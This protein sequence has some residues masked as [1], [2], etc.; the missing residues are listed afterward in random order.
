M[1]SRPWGDF[2][3]NGMLKFLSVA[4]PGYTGPSSRTVQRRLTKLYRK[5]KE[6]F[7]T[8]LAQ[9][10]QLS[11][12]A[13]LWKSKRNRHFL[14]ITVHYTSDDFVPK[15][16]VLSFKKFTGR[17][18]A[19]TIRAH[20]EKVINEY[21]LLGKITSTTTDNGSNI[22]LATSK[23]SLFGI[24]IHCLCHALNLTIFNGLKLWEKKK[25][26]EADNEAVEENK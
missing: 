15:S 21:S 3:R 26:V 20:M 2:K 5:K 12:T 25:N 10:S 9:T 16:K 24:R 1:D 19:K 7:K 18:Y 11:L 17:H 4:V 8:E 23:R 22:R 13:D 6:D 14:C